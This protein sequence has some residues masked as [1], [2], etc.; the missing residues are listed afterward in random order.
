MVSILIDDDML[1]RSYQPD[2][3]PAL[4][5]AVNESRQH[6]RPWL[7]WIDTTTKPE[8]TLQFIQQS[9]QQLNAQEGLALGIVYK[10]QIIGGIGMHHWD[11]N[12]KKAQLGYWISQP[13]EGQSIIYK[14][15]NRFID[16]LFEKASLNKLEI[17]FISTNIRS[18]RVAE[19]LGFRVEGVIRKSQLQNGIIH[20]VVI[21]GLLKEEW[22]K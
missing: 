11:H 6:L 3:A 8:H 21:T 18:A 15:L 10:R 4:F 14:C 16:F 1:L 13:Y 19:R 5:K 2:D 22:N 17:H 12:I 9:L 7:N 20:D